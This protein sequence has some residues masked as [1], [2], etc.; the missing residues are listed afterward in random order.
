MSAGNTG[1][2]MATSKL[3]LGSLAGVQRPALA[4][5]VPTAG[6]GAPS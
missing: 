4:T 2:V 5:V 3:M 1:A 6:G